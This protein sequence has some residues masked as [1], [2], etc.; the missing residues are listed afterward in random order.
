MEN[1]IV[2]QEAGKKKVEERKEAA[3]QEQKTG[4]IRMERSRR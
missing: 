2:L 3:H 1:P 4:S